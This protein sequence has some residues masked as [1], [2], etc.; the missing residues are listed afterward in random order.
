M[1]LLLLA[2]VTTGVMAVERGEWLLA[3]SLGILSVLFCGYVI[4]TEL[5]MRTLSQKL[6][7]EEFSYLE[8]QARESILNNKIKELTALRGALEA[9]ALE[10]RPDKA[11]ETIMN[12]AC[13]LC[14]AVRGSVMLVDPVSQRFI[15][16]VSRGLKPEYLAQVQ[17]ISHSVAGQVVASGRPLLITGSIKTSD[18][19]HFIKKEAAPS[20]SLCVPLRANNA[21]IGVLNCSSNNRIFTEYDLQLMSLFAHYA[22]LVLE[23]GLAALPTRPAAQAAAPAAKPS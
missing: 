21:V 2:V 9:L 17:P 16:P 20:S 5:K 19:A 15:I 7:D 12:E 4:D 1:G 22:E 10:R 6:L 14:D 3:A 13:A 18:V 23:R 11:L 8:A